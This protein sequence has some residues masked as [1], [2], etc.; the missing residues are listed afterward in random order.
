MQSVLIAEDDLMIADMLAEVLS[1]SGFK[2]CG[3]ARTV[4]EGIALGLH[5]KPDLALL[6]LRLAHGG[7]G[8]EIAAELD[9]STGLGILYTTGNS[10]Q[11]LLTKEDGDACLDK[12]FRPSDVV[13]SLKLVHEFNNTGKATAPF[14]SGFRLL[15]GSARRQSKP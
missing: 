8:T 1:D 3:I 15:D 14:P 10:R 6:D 5:H 7:L 4:K 13:R 11:I 2:V 12:P 9:R